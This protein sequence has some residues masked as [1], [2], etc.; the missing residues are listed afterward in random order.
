MQKRDEDK[1]LIKKRTRKKKAVKLVKVQK[2]L[3]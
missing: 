1:I 3:R 2:P